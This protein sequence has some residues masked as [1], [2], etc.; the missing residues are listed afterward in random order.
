MSS[1]RAEDG[2][3]IAAS[4]GYMRLVEELC[5]SYTARTEVP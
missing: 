5:T 2:L 4:A 3:T 1:L